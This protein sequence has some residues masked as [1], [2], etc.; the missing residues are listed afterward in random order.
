MKRFYAT[1][2]ALLCATPLFAQS[3]VHQ[4]Y[5]NG[6]PTGGDVAPRTLGNTL[7][8][9]LRFVTDYLGGGAVWN[10]A[11][12]TANLRQGTQNMVFV[13]GSTRATVNGQGRALLAP[14]RLERGRILLPLRDVANLMHA[15]V[16]YNQG[17]GAVFLTVANGSLTPTIRQGRAARRSNRPDSA[18]SSA[19][20]N[21]SGPVSG[22]AP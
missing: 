19:A 11:T 17:S 1:I 13:V 21:G 7:Y 22:S 3:S 20:R 15:Q 8:V 18:A 5:V 14:V 6:Q 9:P 12:Q 10:N 16:T 2:A 4:L